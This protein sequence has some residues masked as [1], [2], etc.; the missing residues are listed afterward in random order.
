M[1]NKAI[2][3]FRIITNIVFFLLIICGL[4]FA[5]SV[6]PIPGNYKIFSV[7]S[8]SMEPVVKRGSIVVVR[9][10]DSYKI[11]DIITF[12]NPVVSKKPITH[13]IIDARVVG[14]KISYV[15]K[16]DANESQDMND[17]PVGSIIGKTLFSVPFIG[18]LLN[19][20]RQPIGFIILI[21]VPV[22]I[23]IYGQIKKI[24][25]EAA[26]IAKKDEKS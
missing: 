4:F 12:K 20:I 7:E 24:K 25:N 2:K 11:G 13:R 19:I 3:F 18:Y 8:G 21:I 17:I 9:F 14:G 23:I 5:F 22:A 1:D 15:T 26:R 16:G 6:I 10:T